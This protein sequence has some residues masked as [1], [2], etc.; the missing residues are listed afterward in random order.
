MEFYLIIFL[1]CVNFSL[2]YLVY[3]IFPPYFPVQ[4]KQRGIDEETI[5]II[6]SSYFFSYAIMAIF[7]S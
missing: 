5:G 6:M 2:T 7:M 4:A 3:S 1:L